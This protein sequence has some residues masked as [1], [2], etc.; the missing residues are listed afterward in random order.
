MGFEGRVSLNAGQR[1]CRMFPGSPGSILQYFE[2]SLSYHLSLNPF[3]SFG[4]LLKTGF[5]VSAFGPAHELL[6]VPHISSGS[7]TLEKNY[8][9]S[10]MP[11]SLGSSICLPVSSADAPCKEYKPR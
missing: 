7:H 10:I 1:Y 4:W 2:T 8:R 6:V 5:T 11:N 9:P 3:S